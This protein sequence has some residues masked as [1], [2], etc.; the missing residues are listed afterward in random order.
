MGM[1]TEPITLSM[2]RKLYKVRDYLEANYVSRV[3]EYMRLNSEHRALSKATN[4]ELN[5]PKTNDLSYFSSELIGDFAT[6]VPLFVSAA[7][8]SLLMK[9]IDGSIALIF[10]LYLA[11]TF[12]KYKKKLFDDEFGRMKSLA[13]R[14]TMP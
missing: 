13:N 12:R 2:T 7:N 14:I 8:D 3:I 11:N 9:L 1:K 4:I 5:E 10:Q 6:I